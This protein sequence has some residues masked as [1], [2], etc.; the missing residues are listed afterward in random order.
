[1]K[2][3]VL[4]HTVYTMLAVMLLGSG[5]AA[6]RSDIGGAYGTINSDHKRLSTDGEAQVA[7]RYTRHRTSTYNK[8]CCMG[9][10]QSRGFWS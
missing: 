6:F 3:H 9:T 4:L 5:C 8:R 2:L 1:M 7:E 10:D